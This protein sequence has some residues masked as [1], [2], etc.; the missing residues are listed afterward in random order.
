MSSFT[1]KTAYATVRWCIHLPLR[2]KAIA[3][4]YGADHSRQRTLRRLSNCS[5]SQ[6]EPRLRPLST[7]GIARFTDNRRKSCV[8]FCSSSDG[9]TDHE[10]EKGIARPISTPL[11]VPVDSAGTYELKI[12]GAETGGRKLAIVFTCTVCNTR[13]A[14]QFSEQA[15]NRGVVIV[16]CPGCQNLHLIADRLGYFDEGEFDLNSIAETAGEQIKTFTDGNILE[17]SLEDV[18]GKEKMEQVLKK[19]AEQKDSTTFTV[20]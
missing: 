4:G 13:S 18:I 17:M 14:K 11:D 3:A 9:K 15:Y 7:F 12:P 1:C 19:S 20:S 16:R 10:K 2:I 5:L 6:A 8:P